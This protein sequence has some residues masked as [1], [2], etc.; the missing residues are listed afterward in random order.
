MY[1]H[2]D[3]MREITE[4]IDNLIDQKEIVNPDWVTQSFMAAHADLHGTDSECAI[5]N[6]RANVRSEVRRH[7]NK[8][9]LGPEG[10]TDPQLLLPGFTRMQRVYL[11]NREGQQVGVPVEHLTREEI[12]AKCAEL[13]AM[14]DGCLEHVR[15]L[16]R[17]LAD[18]AAASC[19]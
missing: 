17:Y 5:F 10:D 7:L 18:R 1:N 11:V 19:S 9:K 8:F 3:L 4:N 6:M 16:R 12:Q 13:L 14:S 15:E 2:A